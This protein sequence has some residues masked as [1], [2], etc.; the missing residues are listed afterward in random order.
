MI[1]VDHYLYVKI[2][3]AVSVYTAARYPVAFLVLI[4]Q[5]LFH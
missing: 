1:Y 3:Y 2:N 5:L 4:V